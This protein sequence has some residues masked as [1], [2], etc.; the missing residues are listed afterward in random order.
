MGNILDVAWVRGYIFGREI[1]MCGLYDPTLLQ[2]NT[3]VCQVEFLGTVRTFET[4]VT[5]M[6]QHSQKTLGYPSRDEKFTAVKKLLLHFV[7]E[8]AVPISW[9]PQRS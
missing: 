1:V 5:S 6:S 8:I 9:S 3:L 4:S 7:H 2:K